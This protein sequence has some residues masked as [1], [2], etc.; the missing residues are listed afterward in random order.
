MEI[1][2]TLALPRDEFSVPVVRRVLAGALQAPLR[3]V[4]ASS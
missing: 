2:L 1:K 3:T 4:A